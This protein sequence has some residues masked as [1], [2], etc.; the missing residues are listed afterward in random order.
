M[1]KA[2]SIKNKICTVIVAA[3]KA[4]PYI[5]EAIKS[6]LSQ[7]LPSGWKL[8]LIVGID[9]CP[10]T[11]NRIK[12]IKNDS[13]SIYMMSKN[14]GTY[15]TFNTMFSFCNGD[16]ICRFDADDI[17]CPGYLTSTISCLNR[18][19]FTRYKFQWID[20]E[21]RKQKKWGI[22]H[23]QISFKREVW[24]KLGGFQPWKCGADTDFCYRAEMKFKSRTMQNKA[25]FL[26][27]QAPGQLTQT[28]KT[29]YGSPYRSERN[30]QIKRMQ[31]TRLMFKVVPLIAPCKKVS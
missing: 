31:K 1:S 10:S 2:Q 26:R 21:G 7:D 27:R 19:S 9:S 12:K 29:G 30:Q 11:Y 3:Y 15:T 23:G 22:S 20:V 6:I 5:E 18:C 4:E 16:I 13:L 17:M 14:S 8:E 28:G 24:E 25:Y